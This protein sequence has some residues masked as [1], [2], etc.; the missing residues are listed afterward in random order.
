MTCDNGKVL[1]LT[2]IDNGLEQMITIIHTVGERNTIENLQKHSR[3]SAT[4]GGIVRTFFGD[5]ATKVLP[6]PVVIDDHN[7]HV[8]RV[9]IED[10]F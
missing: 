8:E 3:L 10:Q 6:I 2:W 5:C 7:H 9:D 1:A 4:N